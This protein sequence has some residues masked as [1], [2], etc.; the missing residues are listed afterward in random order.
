[1]AYDETKDVLVENLGPVPNTDLHAEVR[2]YD[3]GEKKLSV[4]R[5]YG[6][7]NDKRSQVFRLSYGVITELGEFLVNF[8]ATHGTGEEM[9]EET[10]EIVTNE[11]EEGE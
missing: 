8:T 5:K 11:D 6:K 10:T 4:F 3:G 2:V 7:N 9:V 1:M